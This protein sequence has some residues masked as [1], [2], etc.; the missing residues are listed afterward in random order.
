MILSNVLT[1]AYAPADD[2]EPFHPSNV[3]VVDQVLVVAV[4]Q[5]THPNDEANPNP[6]G[7]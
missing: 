7:A 3:V 6:V 2:I 4:P 5:V 1:K